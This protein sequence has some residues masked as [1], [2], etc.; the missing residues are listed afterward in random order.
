MVASSF[1]MGESPR[2][3]VFSQSASGKRS[4]A[5]W[6][7]VIAPDLAL[8]RNQTPWLLSSQKRRAEFPFVIVGELSAILPRRLFANGSRRSCC[9]AIMK[10]LILKNW[11]AKL[12]SL[13]L[14]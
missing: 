8:P 9:T 6:D 10:R 11:R 4:I 12:I 7:Y 5:A 2:R 13:L 3:P 14:A 1:A